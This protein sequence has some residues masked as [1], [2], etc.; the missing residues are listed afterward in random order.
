MPPTPRACRVC[1]PRRVPGS[2]SA[3]LLAGNGG[4]P[5]H[6]CSCCGS[7]QSGWLSAVTGSW[8]MGRGSRKTGLRGLPRTSETLQGQGA[9]SSV[10][11]LCMRSLAREPALDSSAA[12]VKGV[13]GPF[14]TQESRVLVGAS[15]RVSTHQGPAADH[16][17]RW[18][19]GL[20][21]QLWQERLSPDP[22]RDSAKT[23]ADQKPLKSLPHLSY[24]AH[25]FLAAIS[26][27][28]NKRV[29]WA[30]MLLPGSART[31]LTL[32]GRN[33]RA[34][35]GTSCASS[36]LASTAPRSVTILKPQTELQ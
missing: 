31:V 3:E 33:T 14:S 20:T 12:P 10:A 28:A 5:L 36:V 15:C 27:K 25:S 30:T 9:G 32:A 2:W 29:L 34:S 13:K 26:T 22:D 19:W 18:G 4:H 8:G 11:S 24:H 7:R 21:F 35:A 17:G 1:F 6:T 16:R 23:P